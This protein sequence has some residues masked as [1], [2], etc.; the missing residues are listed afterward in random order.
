MDV[1]ARVRA[2]L[3]A[4]DLLPQGSGVVVAVSGGP[5][6]LCL[7]HVLLQMRGALGL[8]L[9]V[10]HL[11]HGLRPES[12]A[13]AAY[14]ASLAARWRLP[15]TIGR[16]D[17]HTLARQERRSIEEAAR[18]ARYSFLA[19]VA[20][21]QGMSIVAV[22]HNADDQ[23]ETVLMHCLRGAGLAGLRGMRRR[24]AWPQA[25]LAGC[26]APTLVRPLLDV[27]RQ[28][29]EAYCQAHGLE[30]R[31]DRTNLDV[32]P[33]R[34]RIRH[35]LVPLL[36]T[37]NPRLRRILHRTADL[38]AD[39]YACLQQALQAHWPEV[40]LLETPEAV[41]L[42]REAF[43]QLAPSPQRGLLRRAVLSLR[44]S[45][46]DVGSLH[47]ERARRAALNAPAGR[48]VTL[49]AGLALE[50]SYD[51]L[52]VRPAGR[53]WQPPE[54][55]TLAAPEQPLVVPGRTP[56]AEGWAIEAQVGPEPLAAKDG[57]QVCFDAAQV[58]GDLWLRGRRAGDRFQPRGMGGRHKSVKDYMIDARIPRAVRDCVPLLVSQQGILW[59]VGWRASELA[60]P[61]AETR[62]FLCLRLLPS[63]AGTEEA[64]T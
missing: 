49:P 52:I 2:T 19:R 64:R 62:R 59:I 37:Y 63:S 42:H 10:A 57:H 55:P 1:A 27:P 40:V 34:N 39:D 51:H 28:A 56:L 17:V 3:D 14:V 16:A 41:V 12:A 60:A 53:P 25:A 29:I 6:S 33:F 36:E 13:D 15:H 18:V 48:Q 4:H 61:S 54:V 11:D 32:T 22:G 43:R 26:R 24:S 30:P 20:C 38:L 5:D 23:V 7:L 9:H 8:R 35:E 50:V 44:Q 21:E 58:E 47:L 46:R 45:L 31:Y